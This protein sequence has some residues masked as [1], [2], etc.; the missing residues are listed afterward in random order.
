MEHSE[1]SCILV[2]LPLSSSVVCYADTGGE[3]GWLEMGVNH[4]GSSDTATSG[5]Y[6]KRNL[7]RMPV[8]L[9]ADCMECYHCKDGR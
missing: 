6:D 3:M 5:I 4:I 2:Y 1:N 9:Y 7:G 8:Q